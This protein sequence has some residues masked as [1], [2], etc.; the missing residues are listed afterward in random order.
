MRIKALTLEG[1]RRTL[2]EE[3]VTTLAHDLVQRFVPPPRRL[4]PSSTTSANDVHEAAHRTGLMECYSVRKR[5]VF[6][7]CHW[8]EQLKGKCAAHDTGPHQEVVAPEPLHP[9]RSQA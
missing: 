2:V 9:S 1:Q 3:L 5:T 4:L 6:L 7:H 8:L